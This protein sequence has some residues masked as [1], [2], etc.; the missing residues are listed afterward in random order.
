MRERKRNMSWVMFDCHMRLHIYP[1]L[2]KQHHIEHIHT[3]MLSHSTECFFQVSP[4]FLQRPQ[5]Q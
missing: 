4:Y 2:Q 3:S 1:L 5:L